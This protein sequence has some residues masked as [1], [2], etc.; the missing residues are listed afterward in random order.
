MGTRRILARCL[1]PLTLL[2]AACGGAEKKDPATALTDQDEGKAARQLERAKG[3]GDAERF[4]QIIQRFPATKAADEAREELAKVLIGQ[5]EAALAKEDWTTAEERAEEAKIHAGLELTTRARA[6][7]DKI[8]EVRAVSLAEDAAKLAAEGKCASA[9]KKVAAP[10]RK[11]PRERLRKET[12]KL[13]QKTLVECIAKKLEEELLAGNLEAARTMLES[14]DAT[15]ALSNEG[16]QEATKALERLVVRESTKAIQPMLRESKWAEALAALDALKEKGELTDREHD[17]AVELVQDAATKHLIDLASTAFGSRSP[18]SVVSSIEAQVKAARFKAVP[19]A[20]AE[21]V[22]QLAAA[23]ECERVKCRLDRPRVA[24]A[25]G[26]IDVTEPASTAGAKVG[27]IAHAQSFWILGA[28]KTHAL[29]AVDDPAG[30][31]GRGAYEKATGWVA[32]DHVRSATTER[33][34]PPTDQLAGVRVWGP[35][36]PPERAYHLGTVVKVEGSKVTVKRMSD[37]MEQVVDL[38]DLRMGNVFKGLKVKAF[39]VDELHPEAAKVESVVAEGETPKIQVVCEKGG[40]T[41]VEVA[42]A[43]TTQADWLPARQPAR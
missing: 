14:A 28:G 3:S 38:G 33:W 40:K 29:V 12:H 2:A 8:D 37:S 4:R 6:V 11:K 16:Y 34:L 25:W 18:A 27:K 32:M 23:I 13:T 31:T 30:A 19:D 1:V 39:C 35:L 26:S 17:V 10:L 7:L 22:K 21:L 42:S 5:A 20:L 43:L 9:L 36:R 24:W 15:T 41:R